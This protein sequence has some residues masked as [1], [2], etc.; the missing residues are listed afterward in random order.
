MNSPSNEATLVAP[1]PPW[2]RTPEK[3][4]RKGRFG[5]GAEEWNHPEFDYNPQYAA[6]IL[7]LF[8]IEAW[9]RSDAHRAHI[10]AFAGKLVS[11]T[12]ER[13]FPPF[14][15][16]DD[17]KSSQLYEWLDALAT[18]VARAIV[19]M[20]TDADALALIEP[21]TNHNHRDV[22]QFADQLTDQLTRRFVYDASVLPE[23]VLRMLDMLMTRM[24]KE[25]DFS[26][27]GYRPGEVHDRH[28]N[29]MIRSFM[30]VSAK[31]CPGAARFANGN[32]DNLPA[33]L[34]QIDRLMAAA[35]WADSVM[36]KFL[37]L[38]ERAITKMPI[39][40]FERMVSA[41]MEA[42]GFRL[43][44]WNAAGIPAS[45]SGVIQGLADANYPLTSKQARC[46]L[47]ILDRL[48]DIGDRRAAALQQSEHFRGIQVDTTKN[49]AI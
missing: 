20:P 12:A 14:T 18:L 9:A 47:V 17:N 37:T 10:L 15:D 43:E 38:N 36:D 44:R 46:L 25:R 8:P 3:L 35:G 6:G 13:M 28:L 2:V 34:G 1:P 40:D 45:I 19:Y 24:L 27:T 39:E 21:I 7:K 26:P 23:R 49:E 30:L 32:W 48:V 11:W 22:L 29:S 31:D 5:E 33:L 16:G 41:S 4:R 42:E